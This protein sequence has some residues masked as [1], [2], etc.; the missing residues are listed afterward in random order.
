MHFH[1]PTVFLVSHYGF[2]YLASE[3]LGMEDGFIWITILKI[4][5]RLVFSSK[6]PFIAITRGLGRLLEILLSLIQANI[7]QYIVVHSK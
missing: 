3:K 2:S 1:S 5:Y 4:S 7:N 6:Y